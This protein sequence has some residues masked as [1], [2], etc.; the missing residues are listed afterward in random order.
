LGT[1]ALP[2]AQ[3]LQLPEFIPDNS[4]SESEEESS[5]QAAEET[6][7]EG[8]LAIL[9]STTTT[10]QQLFDQ[11]AANHRPPQLQVASETEDDEAVD[12]DVTATSYPLLTI[13]GNEQE[14]ERV[15]HENGGN[16][17]H[18]QRESKRSPTRSPSRQQHQ[19]QSSQARQDLQG[20]FI[21]LGTLPY[22]KPSASGKHVKL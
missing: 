6:A 22:S 9:G 5:P 13:H 17:H 12:L 14:K 18:R 7:R 8:W 2:T 20:E 3:E 11:L 1:V 19:Q 16:I 10:H 21:D 4:S 15:Q